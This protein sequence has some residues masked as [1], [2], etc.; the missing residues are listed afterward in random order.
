MNVTKAAARAWRLVSQAS[1]AELARR[2]RR[3]A[4]RAVAQ[5][6]EVLRDE[7]NSGA[8]DLDEVDSPTSPQHVV[9]VHDV[10]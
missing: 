2:A 4:R 8:V 6:L 3:R 10:V 1:R 7:I 5:D 9:G